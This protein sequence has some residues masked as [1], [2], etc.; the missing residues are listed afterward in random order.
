MCFS[1]GPSN[2][3]AVAQTNPAPHPLDQAYKD[4][5]FSSQAISPG[6][7]TV[8]VPKAVPDAPLEPLRNQQT[9]LTFGAGR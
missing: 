7:A 4:V 2:Q 6:D 8:P 9:G 1:S 5:T 3:P